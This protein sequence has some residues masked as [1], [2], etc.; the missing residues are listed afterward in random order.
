MP[1]G[2]RVGALVHRVLES[3]DFAAPDLTAELTERVAEQ[4]A[5]GRVEIGDPSVVTAGLAAAVETPFSDGVSALRLRNLRRGG[6]VGE[7]EVERP[8]AGGGEPDPRGGH[9]D[10]GC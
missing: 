2:A 10:G 8:P 5:Q 3:A 9:G 4:Q 7:P 1:A 6:R